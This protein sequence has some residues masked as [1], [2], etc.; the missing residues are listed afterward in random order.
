MLAGKKIRA[1]REAAGLTPTE[2]AYHLGVSHHTVVR[3]ERD[4]A[5]WP[6]S[7]ALRLGRLVRVDPYDLLAS[8]IPPDGRRG[9]AA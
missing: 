1:A 9:S 3:A 8:P 4:G 5:D 6:V 7:R 2:L